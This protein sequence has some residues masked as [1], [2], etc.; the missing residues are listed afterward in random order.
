MKCV[1]AAAKL[2]IHEVVLLAA[3]GQGFEIA[4]GPARALGCV[5]VKPP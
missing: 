3:R 5:L 1:A 4:L 2:G